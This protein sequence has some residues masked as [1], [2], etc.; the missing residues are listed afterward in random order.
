MDLY[1]AQ[2]VSYGKGN[3]DKIQR[4]LIKIGVRE[5]ERG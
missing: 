2:Y 1:V 5:R 3:F 4:C